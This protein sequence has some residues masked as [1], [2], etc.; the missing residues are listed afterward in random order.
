MTIVFKC[1]WELTRGNCHRFYDPICERFLTSS[2]TS[3]KSCFNIIISEHLQNKVGAGVCTWRTL[4]VCDS[5]RSCHQTLSCGGRCMTYTASSPPDN[6]CPLLSPSINRIFWHFWGRKRKC[7]KYTCISFINKI[8]L[9]STYLYFRD[10]DIPPNSVSVVVIIRH[11]KMD[12]TCSV[13]IIDHPISITSDIEDNAGVP[14]FIEFKRHC[15]LR[16]V[17]EKIFQ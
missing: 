8:G 12:T 5:P 13:L 17:Y 14:R 10:A 15:T 7:R 4:P 3:W 2:C 9:V 6:P 11:V 1:V 16:A